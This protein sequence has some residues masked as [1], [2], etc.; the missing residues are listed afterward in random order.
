MF[1]EFTNMTWTPSSSKVDITNNTD[2]EIDGSSKKIVWTDG[3]AETVTIGFDSINLNNYEE[4]SFYLSQSFVNLPSILYT[5]TVGGQTYSFENIVV[6]G[7]HHVLI[8][9]S[10]LGTVTNIVITAA[11]DNLTL[12][13]DVLGVRKVDYT[14]DI[15]V[16]TAV[17]E[18]ISLDYNV[19]TT[20]ATDLASTA[21]S[22]S[23]TSSKYVNNTS[24]IEVDN[25]SGTTV[26]LQLANKGGALKSSPGTAFSSGDTVNVLCPTVMGD[27]DN[28]EPDPV[29]GVTFFDKRV[30]NNEVYISYLNGTAHKIFTGALGVLV[31]IDCSSKKKLL[32]LI[33]EYNYNYGERFKILLDGELVFVLLETAQFVEDSIGNNPRMAYFYYIEPQPITIAKTVEISTLTLTVDSEQVDSILE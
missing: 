20:L 2:F 26:E 10:A 16:L 15:D 30:G 21:M 3:N 25:G 8:D 5:I 31:Y 33:S 1:T 24:V 9:C 28:T 14:N 17:K 4:I 7:W 6:K 18:K 13:I 29:C 32:Q 11:T 22:V 23:L 12:F 19:S 27:Y